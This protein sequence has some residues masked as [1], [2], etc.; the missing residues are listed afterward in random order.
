MDKQLCVFPWKGAIFDLDGTIIDSMGVWQQIDEAFL[1]RRHIMVDQDYIEAVKTLRY[2]DAAVYTIERYHLPETVQAVM[3]EWDEMALDAYQNQIPCKPGA[4][5][6]ILYLKEKGV[7]LALAT[8]SHAGLSQAV[9]K[10]HGLDTV[11]DVCT[12]VSQVSR[13]KE[14]PDLYLLAAERMALQPEQCVV[15]EDILMGIQAVKRTGFVT[16]GIQDAS[17]AAE[18]AAIQ[19]TADFYLESFL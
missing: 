14:E 17:S 8:V 2:E 4:K 9:L 12:D 5:E 7:K 16:C 10:A 11:F 19:Q 15:F 6:Y 18:K 13:G 1:K 3:E